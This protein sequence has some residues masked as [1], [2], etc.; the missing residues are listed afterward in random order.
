MAVPYEI[1]LME[2]IA[3]HLK[4]WFQEDSGD[5]YYPS[6]TVDLRLRNGI[7]LA[8]ELVSF[9]EVLTWLRVNDQK[10]VARSLEQER[11][12]FLSHLQAVEQAIER[13]DNPPLELIELRSKITGLI[14]TLEHT[15]KVF[16]DNLTPKKPAETGRNTKTTIAAIVISLLIICIFELLVHLGP[17][18]WFKNHHNSYSLQGSIICL[19]FCLIVGFFKP[20]SR[21]RWWGGAAFA[22]LV[23]LVSLL[24]GAGGNS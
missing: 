10:E 3:E 4:I 1:E 21:K 17:L 5:K 7:S 6:G 9:E 18:A 22:F 23:L 12:S 13:G 8:V 19:I 14:G 11:D 20:Q 15:A 2:Q 16:T 24:G